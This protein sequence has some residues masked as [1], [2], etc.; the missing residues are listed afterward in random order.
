MLKGIR[1]F[2][3]LSHENCLKDAL[4]DCLVEWEKNTYN[5][6]IIKW[7]DIEGME[8]QQL[9]RYIYPL[10]LYSLSSL[11]HIKHAPT[12]FSITWNKLSFG[13]VFNGIAI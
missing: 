4:S 9:Y 8:W 5:E 7:I 6:M 3:C 10:M 2:F 11:F 12:I 1:A 13:W